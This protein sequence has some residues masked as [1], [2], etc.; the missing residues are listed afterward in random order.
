LRGGLGLARDVVDA[1]VALAERVGVLAVEA[2][3]RGDEPVEVVVGIR[4]SPGPADGIGAGADRLR[5]VL[6]LSEI[7]DRVIREGHIV[8]GGAC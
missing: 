7:A 5:L 8:E 3:G 2:P 6:Q 1:V 4:L